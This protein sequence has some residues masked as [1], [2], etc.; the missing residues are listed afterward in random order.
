MLGAG[1][2]KEIRMTAPYLRL[3][4]LI[5]MM[6]EPYR[7]ACRRIYDENRGRFLTARG[8]T[9]NHQ[10]WPGGYHDHVEEV[11]NYAVLLY[12]AERSTGRPIPFTLAEAL[13]V[14]FLHDLEK[15]WRFEPGGN[16]E[17]I[18]TGLM[19]TKADREA[20]RLK[21]LEEYGIVLAPTME[22]AMK[23]VEGEHDDYS[24]TRRVSNEL[25]AFCHLCDTWSA[26]GRYDYPK[27]GDPWSARTFRRP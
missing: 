2:S 13:T 11:T 5:D 20:F 4:D 16:G 8:S 9:H 3:P 19:K 21:K 14:L 23:Y 26:R 24:P 22:N 1:L 12:A 17:W 10:A 6:D 15:P 25:A 18:N 27:I 7:S